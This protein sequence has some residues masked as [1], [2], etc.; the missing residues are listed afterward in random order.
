MWWFV[1]RASGIVVL[2]CSTLAVGLGSNASTPGSGSRRVTSLLVHR[3]AA[4]TT[5]ALLPVHILAIVADTYVSVSLSASLI[6]FVSSYKPIAVGLGTLALW[7]FV[8]ITVTGLLRGKLAHWPRLADKWRPVHISSWAVWVLAMAHG[9]L[10]GSDTSSVW[11]IALYV[12]S[13]VFVIVMLTL[14]LRTNVEGGRT[15]NKGA[16]EREHEYVRGEL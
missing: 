14:R 10:T 7:G 3:T 1:A 11:A 12:A 13:T 9:I 4:L 2:I 5:L 15:R 8:L 16:F 6:P